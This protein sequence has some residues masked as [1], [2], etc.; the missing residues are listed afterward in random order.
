MDAGSVMVAHLH[1]RASHAHDRPIAAKM[2]VVRVSRIPYSRVSA[3]VA[4][5]IAVTNRDEHCH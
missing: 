3:V 1:G 5:A 2:R 4:L